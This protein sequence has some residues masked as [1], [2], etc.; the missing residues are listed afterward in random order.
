MSKHL[1]DAYMEY[2]SP[3]TI[4][5]A[6]HTW[7][8]IAGVS[9]L[10]ERRVW[11]NHG[12]EQ[13]IYPN[14]YVILNGWA[15]SGKSSAIRVVADIIK[16]MNK[17]VAN[18]NKGICF[19]P[20]QCTPAAFMKL[21]FPEAEK[22]YNLPTFGPTRQSPMFSAASEFA[23]FVKDLG[24]GASFASDLME[25]YDCPEGDYTKA[26]IK[27]GIDPIKSPSLVI[28]G[29]TVPTF[30]RSYLPKEEARD[31]LASRT[32]FVTELEHRKRERRYGKQDL[33]LKEF[34]DR[35][36]ERIYRMQGEIVETPGAKDHLDCWHNSIHEPER[37]GHIGSSIIASYMSRRPLHVEK[38]AMIMCVCRGSDYKIS[39]EDV[40]RAVTLLSAVEPGLFRCIGMRD[41]QRS[42]EAAEIIT[43]MVPKW[44]QTITYPEMFM[45]LSKAGYSLPAGPM[46]N[47]IIA[48]LLLSG[49]LASDAAP[50]Y[51]DRKFWRP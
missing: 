1:L 41:I 18:G 12:F 31:G 45:K 22:E 5:P 39:A 27:H 30:L 26:T 43:Q 3:I 28:L 48:G 29:G 40:K 46:T 15:G 9:A 50:E 34:V 24:D 44:P 35:E 37:L 19:A 10:L 33:L 4:P 14:M 17:R 21:G 51:E 8:L 11:I 7:S 13:M 32:I 16:R 23:A 49:V 38:L 20:N 36:F 6:Y 2:T 42:P 25:Y 47:N